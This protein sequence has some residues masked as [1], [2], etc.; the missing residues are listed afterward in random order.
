MTNYTDQPAVRQK[1]EAVAAAFN[2][3]VF[4]CARTKSLQQQ[5]YGLNINFPMDPAAG[6]YT[7]YTTQYVDFPADSHW[8]A[9][10]TAYY[11]NM[12]NSWIGQARAS[13]VP[14]DGPID[15]Y[16]FCR[17]ISPATNAVKLTM[18]TV[19]SGTI[20]PV[21]NGSL[22]AT[23][24][25]VISIDAIGTLDPETFATNYFVRWVGSANAVIADRFAAATTVQL[26]GDALVVAYFATNKN[27]YLVDFV[28]EGNGRFSDADSVT[29]TLT[30]VVPA[31]G[32][33]SPVTALADPR[34]VFSGW[35]GDYPATG[36][37][38]TITNVNMD[39]TVIAFFWPVPP[40]LS[41]RQTGA[42]V[43]LTWPVSALDFV[44]ESSGRLPGGSWNPVPGVNTNSIS[45]PLS[46][47][48]QF[49]RLRRE[50]LLQ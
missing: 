8:R 50:P 4:Y 36:N 15:L 25:D 40:V 47:T 20:I 39:T 37:P 6:S 44:L 24:G 7:N 38:L 18:V 19:G 16:L 45:L 32:S 33:C 46:T 2:D 9:F 3:A 49:F 5:V 28:T 10:L 14:P 48:N 1:A 13:L 12:T 41:I 21:S 35:G 34:Y 29:N 42:S 26:T 11:Q 30:L 31:G 17:A 22:T 23:N 43:D 27:S